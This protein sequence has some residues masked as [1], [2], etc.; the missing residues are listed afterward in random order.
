MKYKEILNDLEQYKPGKQ[1]EDIK[2]EYGLDKV[3]KLASNENP[4]GYCEKVN[5]VL[6]RYK[7]A[8]LYP[9]N[10]CTDLRE[11]LAGFLNV[12]KENLIF[13]NGS[14]EIISMLSR[15]LLNKGDE[16]ITCIPTF[17][18]YTIEAKI[19]QAKVVEVELKDYK[20]NLNGILEKIN[21]K[22]KIIYIANPNNPTRN[23]NYKK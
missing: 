9:D 11:K 15:A 13:G 19:A 17:P 6:N 22:T 23:N 4:Y 2:K 3:I 7:T 14:T 21:K 20:F 16:I 12:G 1:I 10:N 5:E 8:N 18:M